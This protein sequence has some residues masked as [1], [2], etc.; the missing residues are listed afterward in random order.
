[1]K[2]K[3]EIAADVLPASGQGG[4]MHTARS[5]LPFVLVFGAAS[6]KE[7]LDEQA[8]AF[9]AAT[10]NKVVVSYGASNALAK[11]IEAGAP[12]DLHHAGSGAPRAPAHLHNPRMG[13]NSTLVPRGWPNVDSDTYVGHFSTLAGRRAASV[14]AAV[15]RLG[16]AENAPLGLRAKVVGLTIDDRMRAAARSDA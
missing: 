10:G 13:P 16:W 12:A 14:A 7:A 2:A 15:N 6:L 9:E 11:Q 8:K 5:V 4:L 3:T 1:M